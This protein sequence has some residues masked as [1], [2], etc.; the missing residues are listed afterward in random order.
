M[1]MDHKAD[2]DKHLRLFFLL[3][4]AFSWIF[5]IPQALAAHGIAIP[6]GAAAFLSGP[7]NPAPFGPLVAALLLTFLTGGWKGIIGLLKRGVDFRFKK[8]WLLPILLLPPLIFTGAILLSVSTGT[9]PLDSS[10]LSTPIAAIVAPVMILLT[11]GPLQEEFGWRGYA[12]PRLQRRFTALVS[13]LILGV[14]WWL[15]HLPLVFI[16]DKFMVS[17]LPLF[18]ALMVEIV[19]VTILF[20]WIYNN[21]GGSILA[22]MLFHTFMNWSIWVALPT[23]KVNLSVI[24]FTILLLAM[25]VALV[26]GL[27]GPKRLSRQDLELSGVV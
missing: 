25:V 9:T 18:A 24:G 3:A 19:L 27:W 17:R 5:W 4:Y 13:S 2:S 26:L 8:I 15:W 1:S 23:M 6:T 10:V 14:L 16:P 12:L 7:F 11:A 20:T 21:T 22:A